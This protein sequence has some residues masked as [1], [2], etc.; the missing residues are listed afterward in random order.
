[1]FTLDAAG[2][3]RR[4]ARSGSPLI[5]GTKI[6]IF[7]IFKLPNCRRQPTLGPLYQRGGRRFAGR[8]VSCAWHHFQGLTLTPLS[9]WQF[10]FIR[11]AP[12]LAGLAKEAA[13]APWTLHAPHPVAHGAPPL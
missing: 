10:M 12:P 3:T 7:S 13:S 6:S 8:G 11:H 4:R 5:E 1:M 9:C 2:D